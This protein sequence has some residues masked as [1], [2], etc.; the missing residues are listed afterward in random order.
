MLQLNKEYKNKS[1]EIVKIVSLDEFDKNIFL[2]NFGRSY[3]K[4]GKYFWKEFNKDERY[5]LEL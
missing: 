3:H 4:D 1:E 5:D 2:D